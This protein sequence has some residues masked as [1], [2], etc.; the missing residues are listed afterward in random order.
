MANDRSVA[1]RDAPDLASCSELAA[2]LMTCAGLLALA[3]GEGDDD[4][5]AQLAEQLEALAHRLRA[6]VLAGTAAEVHTELGAA[7]PA[8]RPAVLARVAR[9]RGLLRQGALGLAAEWNGWEP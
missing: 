7:D 8:Q 6:F 4:P 9:A 2:R 3:T 1:R 5:I